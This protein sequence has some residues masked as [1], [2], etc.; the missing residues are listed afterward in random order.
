[1]AKILIDL[2]RAPREEVDDIIDILNRNKVRHYTTNPVTSSAWAFRPVIW[3]EDEKHYL[4]GKTLIG[5]Y[6]NSRRQSARTGN[7]RIEPSNAVHD[8]S[9]VIL[10]A[11]IFGV[12]TIWLVSIITK[13][14]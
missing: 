11:A 13:Y 6:Q 14:A 4:R 7:E 3:T 2:S 10:V 12:V 1:M 5:E 9:K 8:R